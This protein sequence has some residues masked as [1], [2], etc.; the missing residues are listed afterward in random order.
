MATR[1]RTRCHDNM[2]DMLRTC[3]AC[4]RHVSIAA[5]SC[6]FCATS[7]GPV[8]LRESSFHVGRAGR[9]MI[10]AGAVAVAAVGCGPQVQYQPLRASGSADVTSG[11]VRGR[12]FRHDNKPAVGYSITL[13]GEKLRTMAG[14][15]D[16]ITVQTDS[17]GYFELANLP[18]GTYHLATS[19]LGDRPRVDV[20]AGE[21]AMLTLEL[22]PPPKLDPRHMAKPY[23]APPIRRRVV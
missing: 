4:R 12:I 11:A 14:G 17:T 13:Y 23:G 2:P 19:G 20:R 6:V 8:A 7:L 10:F 9:A 16:S 5:P 21:A 1:R 22:E 15:R 3:P 18:P